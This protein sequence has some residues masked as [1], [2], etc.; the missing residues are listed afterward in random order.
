LTQELQSQGIAHVFEI[1][2]EF[3]LVDDQGEEYK[4]SFEFDELPKSTITIKMKGSKRKPAMMRI[5][6]KGKVLYTMES[7]DVPEY[8]WV[9]GAEKAADIGNRVWCYTELIKEGS[10][11][12]M[13]K[14]EQLIKKE[15]FW[16]VRLRGMYKKPFIKAR[17]IKAY[18]P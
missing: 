7:T 8:I 16:G 3:E 12:G 15:P 10:G 5:D 4:A 18:P 2:V 1:E 9:A 14:V 6:S 17:L 11:S 13:R